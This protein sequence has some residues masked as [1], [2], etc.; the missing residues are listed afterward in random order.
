MATAA[1]FHGTKS[2]YGVSAS[3][4]ESALAP[5]SVSVSAPVSASPRLAALAA[6]GIGLLFAALAL[7][8]FGAGGNDDAYITFWSAHTLATEG[9]I[10]N[11]NGDYLEQS[12]SLALTVVL[13]ALGWPWPDWIPFIGRVLSLVSLGLISVEAHGLS[14]SLGIR[15]PF[16][17]AIAAL[18]FGSVLYWATSGMEAPLAAYAGLLMIG[19]WHRWV[20]RTDPPTRRSALAMV[21]VTMFFCAIRPEN[22]V[23]APAMA[24]VAGCCGVLASRWDRAT[25]AA[26]RRALAVASASSGALC[27]FRLWYF[28]AWLPHPALSKS[29]AVRDGLQYAIA[30]LGANN[31]ALLLALPLMIAACAYALYRRRSEP[32]LY[33]L[34]AWAW[35]VLGFIALSGG[36]WMPAHRFLVACLPAAALLTCWLIHQLPWRWSRLLLTAV[37][38]ATSL[39]Q[40]GTLVSQR[41]DPLVPLAGGWRTPEDLARRS[42]TGHPSFGWFEAHGRSRDVLTAQALHRVITALDAVVDRPLWVASGQAGAVNYLVFRDPPHELRFFDQW[43]L[44]V[45]I[46]QCPPAVRGRKTV[47]GYRTDLRD[48]IRDEG[49]F[50]DCGFPRPDVLHSSTLRTSKRKLLESQGY[51]IAYHARY[52]LPTA[53]AFGKE[54][55]LTLD[56]YVAVD[57]ELAREAGLR[58][59][60]LRSP[61]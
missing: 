24:L 58:F 26:W 48:V 41:L 17:A 7:F 44:T 18:G 14:E 45:D 15:R 25:L 31:P 54:H 6:F 4:S 37:F 52:R 36:D 19:R 39:W 38:L 13:A 51:V 57:A 10:L 33:L 21:L 9:A 5:V 22:L 27:L 60:G 47:L 32:A 1:P 12:S 40:V 46:S 23:L 43:G 28:D 55:K 30:G 20:S 50:R 16:V 35:G 53:E 11:Y 49:G 8:V 42:E 34:C 29:G 61:Y 56:G 3:V 2:L 59:E